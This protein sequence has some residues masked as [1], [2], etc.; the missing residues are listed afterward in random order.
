MKW[1]AV[2]L[3]VGALIGC[4]QGKSD[5]E[6][7]LS[8]LSTNIGGLRGDVLAL[9]DIVREMAAKEPASPTFRAPD[10]CFG[11]L[12]QPRVAGKPYNFTVLCGATSPLPTGPQFYI[13]AQSAEVPPEPPTPAPE[14]KK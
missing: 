2:L 11:V 1:F 7:G 10:G 5:L 12:Q 14:P 8:G 3:S 6:R 4:D 13:T 9:G